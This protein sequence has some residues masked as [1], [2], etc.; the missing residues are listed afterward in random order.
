MVTAIDMLGF[1]GRVREITHADLRCLT[2]KDM[3]VSTMQELGELATAMQVEQ[4]IKSKF[5]DEPAKSE[6]ADLVICA[7]AM[8]YGLGGEND[9]LLEIGHRKLDKWEKNNKLF[10]FPREENKDVS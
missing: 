9:Q 5:L 4:G 1:L 7:L 3:L 2:I 10:H 6:A 8:F